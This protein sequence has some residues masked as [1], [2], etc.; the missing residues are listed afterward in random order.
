MNLRQVLQSIHQTWHALRKQAN[1]RL[2]ILQSTL[3]I[4]FADDCAGLL[5]FAR[6]L[7]VLID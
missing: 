4:E 5:N 7:F 6:L 3:R 1:A 2:D